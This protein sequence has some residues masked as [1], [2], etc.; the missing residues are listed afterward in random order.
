MLQKDIRWVS[1][2]ARAEE[3][4]TYYDRMGI[5]PA[6]LGRDETLWVARN[7]FLVEVLGIEKTSTDKSIASKTLTLMIQHEKIQDKY[8]YIDNF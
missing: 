1:E 8:I 5:D 6:G 3:S 2:A 7:S 4:P